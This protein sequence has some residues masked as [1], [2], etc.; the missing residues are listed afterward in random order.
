MFFRLELKAFGVKVC[1]LEPGFHATNMTA[2]DLVGK[3]VRRLFK[4]APREVQDEYGEEFLNMCES[5]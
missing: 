4:E 1:I 2:P 3:A 5:I